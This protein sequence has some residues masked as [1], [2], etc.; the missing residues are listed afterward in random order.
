MIPLSTALAQEGLEPE[1]YHELR[2]ELVT[3]QLVNLEVQ[4]DHVALVYDG[5]LDNL[6]G[7]LRLRQGAQPPEPGDLIAGC[8]LV[9]LR[10]L[11]QG[12]YFFVTT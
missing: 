3:L 5:M 4:N 11:G 9:A 10:P 8:Q 1:T 12:W 6:S 7:F 2:R